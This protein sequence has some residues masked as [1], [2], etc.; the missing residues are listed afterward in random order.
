MV[1]IGTLM[2]CACAALLLGMST[3]TQ[4][5][6][7]HADYGGRDDFAPRDY[8]DPRAAPQ[9]RP[10]MSLDQAVGMASREG[11]VLSADVVDAGGGPAYRVKVLTPQGR[12]RVLYFDAG[13]R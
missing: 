11:R 6:N 5:R 3:A 12:V 8:S 7:P 4:A 1:Q 13:G 2:R 9:R 10:G